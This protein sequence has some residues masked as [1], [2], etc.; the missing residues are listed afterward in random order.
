MPETHGL[1]TFAKIACD[2]APLRCTVLQRVHHYEI[3]SQGKLASVCLH[4]YKFGVPL[5][6]VML[7]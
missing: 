7:F 2:Q 3:D 1:L 5:L 6:L 4:H